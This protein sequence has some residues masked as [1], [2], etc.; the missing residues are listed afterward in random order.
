[1]NRKTLA[2]ATL[3]AAG[4]AALV[5]AAAPSFGSPAQKGK[6]IKGGKAVAPPVGP[7][8]WDPLPAYHPGGSRKRSP[9]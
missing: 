5:A 2:A 9:C 1:M 6:V 3:Y 7:R 8:A 4:C